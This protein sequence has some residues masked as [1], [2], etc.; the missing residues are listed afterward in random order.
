MAKLSILELME[1]IKQHRI[2]A[3]KKRAIGIS[4]LPLGDRDAIPH[5][6]FMKLTKEFLELNEE[7]KK[8]DKKA[9][10]IS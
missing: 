1:R 5:E 6:E 9:S 3:I 8:I 10:S 4:K 2:E 7:W